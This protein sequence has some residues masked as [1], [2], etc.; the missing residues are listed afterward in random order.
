MINFAAGVIAGIIGVF[1]FCW[2]YAATFNRLWGDPCE[3]SLTK[4]DQG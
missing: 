3:S 1:F 2:L 4:S